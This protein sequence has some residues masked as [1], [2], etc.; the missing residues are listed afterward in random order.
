[1][2][3]LLFLTAL[4]VSCGCFRLGCQCPEMTIKERF[5][6]HKTFT[7]VKAK[8]LTISN[9]CSDNPDGFVHLQQMTARI[10]LSSSV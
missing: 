2:L 7:V 9:P 6:N 4:T 3:R 5:Y 1:M 8:V 10:D